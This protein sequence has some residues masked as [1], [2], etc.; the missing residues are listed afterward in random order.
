MVTDPNR[1][2]TQL[3]V[4]S[5]DSLIIRQ[6]TL[7]DVKG[8]SDVLTDSQWFTY[9]SLFSEDYI[10]ELIQQYY[11]VQRIEQEIIS[12]DK[13]WHG[14]LVAVFETRIVGVI[15]GGMLNEDSGE[16]Y[17]LYLD[18]TMRGSGIGS[19]LLKFFTKVQKHQYGAK[20][21][22]VAVAKG[23]NYA[24]PFYEARGFIF[25]SEVQSYGSSVEDN[26]ISLMYK[27]K[28]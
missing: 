27:R 1:Y 13:K 26:D 16:V 9:G 28:I 12:V 5:L 19:R 21:Q 2:I 8:I 4:N 3:E 18:P 22:W 17:V 14:Y 25:Q 11:N 23:N 7:C 10:R 15:G 6:S 20:N 24:I